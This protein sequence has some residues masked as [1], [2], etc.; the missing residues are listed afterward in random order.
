MAF[1][2]LTTVSIVALSFFNRVMLVNMGVE[3]ETIGCILN[4]GAPVF[5]LLASVAAQLEVAAALTV[6]N[7]G[8]VIELHRADTQA[9]I[10]TGRGDEVTVI[11][12]GNLDESVILGGHF[13]KRGL[14]RPV[15]DTG[16][17]LGQVSFC[18]QLLKMPINRRRPLGEF[19]P[20]R[21]FRT[22]DAF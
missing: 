18:Q 19:L 15:I 16:R 21:L 11:F 22:A 4:T 5:G 20:T 10:D 7:D 9:I 12:Q 1:L 13:A 6:I 14:L 8:F 2:T 3:F 17:Q